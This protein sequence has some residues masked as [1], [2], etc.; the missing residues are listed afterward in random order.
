MEMPIYRL[1]ST[2]ASELLRSTTFQPPV[3]LDL[4]LVRSPVGY[5][6]S[7]CSNRLL[8]PSQIPR[9]PIRGLIIREPST[10]S[11]FT[12]LPWQK[13]GDDGGENSWARHDDEYLC[14]SP[15]AKYLG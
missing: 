2:H 12:L 6:R 8:A 10:R 7:L 4:V 5:R 3:N 15:T 9:H 13:F 11:V 14:C 1:T